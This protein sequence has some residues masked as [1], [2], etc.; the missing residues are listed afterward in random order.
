[1]NISHNNMY[2]DI[3]EIVSVN[4]KKYRKLKNYTQQQLAELS[5]YSHEFIRRIESPKSKKYFSISTIDTIAKALDV[6][7][8]VLFT[9]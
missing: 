1:M 6:P 8:T 5:G 4:I 9:K 2:D 7:I 3:Y